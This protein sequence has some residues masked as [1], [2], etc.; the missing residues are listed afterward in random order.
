MFLNQIASQ[1]VDAAATYSAS[2]EDKAT[3]LY[4]FEAHENAVDPR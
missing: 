3:T 1:T 4:F 2:H